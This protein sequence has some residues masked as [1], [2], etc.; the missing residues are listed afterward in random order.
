MKKDDIF[1]QFSLEEISKSALDEFVRQGAQAMIQ[2]AIQE[3]VEEF[4]Q[5][6]NTK[7]VRNGYLPERKILTPAGTLRVKQP[8]VRDEKNKS[9]FK[10]SILPPYARRSPSIEAV[11]STLYLKGVGT[12]QFGEAL[13]ALLGSKAKGLSSTTIT[14]LKRA[15]EKEYL[16]WSKRDLTGEE[17]IYVWADGIYF[18]VRL[19]SDRPCVLF[20][21]GANSQGEK[22]LIAIY[23]GE[24]E[25][26]LSW[27]SVLRDLKKR[28]LKTAPQLAIGDGAL[29]FWAALEEI[30]PKTKAQ[31]CWVHKTAN[32]LDKMPKSTQE[33]AKS[34]IH[35]IYLAETKEEAEVA[36][37][38]FLERYELKYPKS[39]ECLR[40]DR[41]ALLAFY[42]FPAEQWSHIRTTNPIESTFATIRHRAKQTKGCGSRKATL[43]MVYKLAEGAEKKWRKLRGHK[44]ITKIVQG[45]QFKDGVEV[46]EH[47]IVA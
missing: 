7:V 32:V 17:Y 34:M 39:C 6:S 2:K 14:R 18:N 9:P 35:D 11:I 26:K 41:E 43:A 37:D 47:K 44:Q 42:D 8:R 33:K 31:R 16:N 25:S 4:I 29:G 12:S 10:S 1:Q 21:M 28:G 38:E 30:Y 40:K 46:Q 22:K 20:L 15:W 13:E 23:D 36:F 19:G 24:R 3:K 5:A 27:E 45:I